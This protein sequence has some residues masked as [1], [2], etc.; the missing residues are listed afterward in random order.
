M[1]AMRKQI[2]VDFEVS[3]E[4]QDERHGSIVLQKSTLRG[5]WL[6]PEYLTRLCSVTA[7]SRGTCCIQQLLLDFILFSWP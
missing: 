3:A 2:D 1:Q 6:F 5:P 7:P 4:E